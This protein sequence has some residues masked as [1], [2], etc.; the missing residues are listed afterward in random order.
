MKPLLFQMNED[1]EQTNSQKQFVDK[2][3]V[4][5]QKEPSFVE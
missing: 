3:P 5:I 4:F 1:F 2:K